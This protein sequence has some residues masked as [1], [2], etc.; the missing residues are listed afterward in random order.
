MQI[1]RNILEFS[2]RLHLQG[3]DCYQAE[4]DWFE[5]FC[6]YIKSFCFTLSLAWWFSQEKPPFGL[7]I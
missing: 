7:Y 3:L 2:T 1:S 4:V 5:C 6:V